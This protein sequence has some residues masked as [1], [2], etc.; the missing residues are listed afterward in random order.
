[1]WDTSPEHG[2]PSSVRSAH[3]TRGA[4]RE[5]SLARN[6]GGAPTRSTAPQHASARPL[7]D[8]SA[9]SRALG[10]VADA[11]QAITEYAIIGADPAGTI[12]RLAAYRTNY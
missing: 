6:K 11:L 8:V 9:P 10:E 2:Y 3:Q 1:M 7:P 12:Y 5:P 4:E